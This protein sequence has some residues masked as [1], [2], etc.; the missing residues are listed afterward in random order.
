MR[1]VERVREPD[2]HWPW[3]VRG[4]DCWMC[5]HGQHDSGYVEHGGC[6]C[7]GHI[8]W[9]FPHGGPF[10]PDSPNRWGTEGYC[11]PPARQV[12]WWDEYLPSPPVDDAPPHPHW[13]SVEYLP[14]QICG[15]PKADH[16][17]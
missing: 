14:C 13:N 3:N 11:G 8:D 2:G 17:A 10:A 4:E 15:R 12:K 9:S 6:L 5:D 16:A 1:A 7:C